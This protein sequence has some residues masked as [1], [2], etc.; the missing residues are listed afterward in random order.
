MSLEQ[1][2]E[3][4]RA[5]QKTPWRISLDYIEGQVLQETFTRGALLPLMTICEMQFKNGFV[6]LGKSAPADPENF[7]AELG[8]R[9]ARE[10]ALRQSWPLFAFALRNEMCGINVTK[11]LTKLA[12]D[13]PGS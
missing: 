9:F 1:T 13:E 11:D 8:Q 6:V 2:D 7:N 4:S 5:V 10:D 12:G 3:A